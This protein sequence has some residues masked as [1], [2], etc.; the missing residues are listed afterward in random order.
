[1]LQKRVLFHVDDLS[2]NVINGQMCP[3]RDVKP[4][5]MIALA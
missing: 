5:V 1:M 4:F 3:T 2:V